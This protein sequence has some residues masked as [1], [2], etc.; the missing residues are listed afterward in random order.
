MNRKTLIAILLA[1]VAITVQGQ[2]FTWRIEGTV[3]NAATTD[4]LMVVNAETRGMITQ[5]LVKDGNILPA[6]G[7]LDKPAVCCIAKQG[8]PGWIRMFVLESGTVNLKID[9]DLVYLIRIGGTPV[10]NVLMTMLAVQNMSLDTDTYFKKMY[11][12]VSHIVSSYPDHPLSSYLIEQCQMTYKPSEVI[13]LIEKLSP[14]LQTSLK[15]ERLKENLTLALATEEGKIFRE[16][17][18]KTPDGKDTA[19]SEFV[20]KGSYVLADF[21]AS[22]CGPCLEEIPQIIAIY[23]KYKDRGLKVIGIT[24]R[25]APEK[26]DSI[27]QKLG[28]PYPQIY[29]SKPMSIYGVIAIP[30]IILFAPDG[31]I[32]SRRIVSCKELDKKLEVIFPDNK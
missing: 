21:W 22:W 32:L 11:E 3:A 17:M 26:S 15:M 4:T 10:N 28:I 16:L 24:V 25:D 29:E 18:G 8:K 7:T 20:G 14:K 5:L 19:L 6:S 12:A 9:L 13:G 31:T 2:S 23:D 27:V 30:Q 1:I